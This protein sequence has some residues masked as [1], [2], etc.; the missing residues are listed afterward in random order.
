[1]TIQQCK[2]C[3]H[4]TQSLPTASRAAI[5]ALAAMAAMAAMATVRSSTGIRD[6]ATEQHLGRT[7]SGRVRS[8]VWQQCRLS[9]GQHPRRCSGQYQHHQDVFEAISSQVNRW[10]AEQIDIQYGIWIVYKKWAGN[11]PWILGRCRQIHMKHPGSAAGGLLQ[12]A[13]Y[14]ICDRL[15]RPAVAIV[16][17]TPRSLWTPLLWGWGSTSR[18]C[19][20]CTFTLNH[21]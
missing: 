19:T 10:P 13:G 7:R 11:G 21:R 8:A 20:V 6:F 14:V 5:A 3:V 16:A 15:E 17:M 4:S 18:S 9:S 1:M 2:R 12:C